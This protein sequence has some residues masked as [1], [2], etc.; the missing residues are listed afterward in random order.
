MVV[1]TQRQQGQGHRCHGQQ[2][3]GHS[4]AKECS[5]MDVARTLYA[6]PVSWRNKND[7]DLINKFINMQDNDEEGNTERDM[8][9]QVTNSG[10]K[11]ELSGPRAHNNRVGQKWYDT[12]LWQHRITKERK[13]RNLE[14]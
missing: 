12:Q 8:L 6:T 7:V 11:L 14:H 4:V 10:M 5:N 2:N 13:N 3:P 9:T 1:G